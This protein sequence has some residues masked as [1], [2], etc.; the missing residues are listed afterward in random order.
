MEENKTTEIPLDMLTESPWQGRLMPET[1]DTSSIDTQHMQELIKSIGSSGLMQPIIVR[2]KGEKY[3]II[4]GHRRLSAYKALGRTAI[5][6]IEKQC[7]DREA[8]IL[9]IVGNLQRRNLRPLELAIAYRKA[10]SGG[11]FSS[12]RELSV[13]LGKHEAFVGEILNTLRM[14]HRILEDLEKKSTIQDI[15]ILRA[16][17]RVAPVNSD[18]ISDQQFSFYR[19]IVENSL[20]REQ[21]LARTKAMITGKSVPTA[22]VGFKGNRITIH[23]D[24]LK[25][26]QEARKE[27]AEFIEQK[28]SDLLK[29]Q[30][31]KR[32]IEGEFHDKPDNQ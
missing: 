2:R 11:L 22:K 13:A 25:L 15:R 16:I 31:K 17:R 27:L 6:F 28:V 30:V 26:S 18:G 12:Q 21:V 23:L 4:D 1:D 8:Q 10:L 20:T 9:S 3:E 19:E 7:E 29:P 14:D 32:N 5:P 24:A